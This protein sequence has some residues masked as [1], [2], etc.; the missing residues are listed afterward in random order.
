M[1][2]L[3]TNIL[4]F[5]AVF[6]LSGSL[7]SQAIIIPIDEYEA[8]PTLPRITFGISLSATHNSPTSYAMV[9]QYYNGSTEVIYLTYES[10]ILQVKGLEESRANPQKINFIKKYEITEEAFAAIWMLKHDEYPFGIK[11]DKGFGTKSG[12][13]SKAQFGMLNQFGIYKIDDFA[14]GE[15]MWRLMKRIENYDWL[16]NYGAA[17]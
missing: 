2:A 12:I 14:Y 5:I 10:F 4:F 7:F 13:P 6:A 9:R 15:N 8:E 3:K 1:N 16:V 11:R 17:K